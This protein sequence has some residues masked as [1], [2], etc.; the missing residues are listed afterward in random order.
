MVL[1]ERE[2]QLEQLSGLLE[3]CLHGDGS[4]VVLRGPVAVGK[5]ELLHTF[6]EQV[7]GDRVRVLSAAASPVERH[8]SFGLLSQLLHG[9]DAAYAQRAE[10]VIGVEA[11]A[12]GTV[13]PQVLEGVS[14]IFLDMSA[15]EPL[16]I[17]VDD[18]YHADADSLQC[19]LFLARRLR[20]S[21]IMLVL[22]DQ[23][24]SGARHA[25]LGTELSRHPYCTQIRLAPLTCDGVAALLAHDLDAHVAH[26][27]ASAAFAVTGGNPLLVR[28]LAED[29]EASTR[30]AGKEPPTGPVVGDRFAERVVSCLHR[31]EPDALDVVRAIAVLGEAPRTELVA[32][33]SGVGAIETRAL[34]E[35]LNASGL[36]HHGRYRHRAA[37]DAVL[38]D[39]G[40]PG[41]IAW[42]RRAAAM[43]HA[44]GGH[45]T[46]IAHQLIAA[47]ETDEPWATAVLQESAA[48]AT[49]SGQV[50]FA[51][52]CLELAHSLAD[53]EQQRAVSRAV[54][55]E[56]EWR[57]DPARAVRH[58][59][60][61]ADAANRGLLTERQS[62]AVLEY[63]LWHGRVDEAA[64]TLD[65]LAATATGPEAVELGAVRACLEL[66]YPT[67]RR[68][69][70]T[71]T[72]APAH[73]DPR[74]GSAPSLVTTVLTAVR[75]D[76]AVSGDHLWQGLRTDEPLA[77]I[78]LGLL[79]LARPERL[80]AV[81]PWCL[82]MLADAAGHD[83]PDWRGLFTAARADAAL[84]RGDLPAAGRF[85]SAALDETSRAS[86]GVLAG[87]PLACLLTTAVETGRY[88]DA[89]G[90][91]NMPTP[92]A[93][94]ETP[95]G[96]RY[97]RARGQYHLAVGRPYAA[98]S[99]FRTCGQLL[100]D[101]EA[102]G[103]QQMPW[104]I[105]AAQALVRLDRL[106]EARTLLEEQ[107][108]GLPADDARTLGRA[109]RHLAATLEPHERPGLLNDSVEALQAAG[110]RVELAHTLADLGS[111]YAATGDS[112]RAR[113]T[114][115]RA[116]RAAQ[117][118][119]A[120]RLA[121]FLQPGLAGTSPAGPASG[122]AALRGDRAAELS[123]AERRVGGLAAQGHSNRQ[124]AQ[125]LCITVST[126]EQ[127]L[128]Q[129]YRKLRVRNRTDLP[130]FLET[131]DNE[132]G[133][134]PLLADSFSNSS[135]YSP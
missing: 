85:A 86:W 101:W 83:G 115:R 17:G 50:D 120:E 19:L 124:I 82:P 37:Q 68:R 75:G 38:R 12:D 88:E 111:A 130:V 89:A 1:V 87:A 60:Q 109:L 16:L 55:A 70:G 92:G 45:S 105:D 59:G 32:R 58:L 4:V 25:A 57:V 123:A 74:S 51:L 39:F 69:V 13:G 93:L 48:S 40:A 15:E 90:Y 3:N 73:G 35:L 76:V 119:H 79:A 34:V 94:L 61:L 31:L 71:G 44:E 100:L 103:P 125:R 102:D 134:D 110:D 98:L 8:L 5:T 104:R 107:L 10:A 128:T 42:H 63:L 18:V 6:A 2:R 80:A 33:L 23:D 66:C 36:L 46:S 113:P 26:S 133:V 106:D 11:R 78:S 47:G 135:P 20:R 77:R 112:R 129:V 67:Q 97:L 91:L 114:L 84:L 7:A 21:R 43:L 53:D 122:G 65:R 24:R 54:L 132:S 52:D 9:A 22:G 127:H 14:R 29:W 131:A 28:A 126:V 81:A 95:F 64:A 121:R 30:S 96:L 108:D 49:A 118:C 56:A 62:L 27:L 41:R 99:D 117:E 72:P 116:W